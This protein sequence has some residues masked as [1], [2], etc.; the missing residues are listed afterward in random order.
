LTPDVLAP[1]AHWIAELK[2]GTCTSQARL[3]TPFLQVVDYAGKAPNFSSQ[4]AV[5]EF[6]GK[7]MVFRVYLDI[8]YKPGA[9]LNA[10]KIKVIQNKKE[11]TPLSVERALLTFRGWTN[12]PHFLPMESR[13]AW[14]S[15]PVRSIL[16]RLSCASTRLTSSTPK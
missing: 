15:N 8:C 4:D 7:Q 11:I 9:P 3:Q 16:Q 12:L 13:Y 6:Y 5:K 2:E 10:I 1:Y 14:N